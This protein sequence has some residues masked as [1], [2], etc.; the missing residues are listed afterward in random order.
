MSTQAFL[1]LPAKV[2]SVK[3]RKTNRALT[4]FHLIHSYEIVVTDD[5][6]NNQKVSIDGLRDNESCLNTFRGQRP[7]CVHG[8]MALPCILNKT[9][10]A[11]S[12]KQ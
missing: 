11:F 1:L 3:I 6:F 2:L 7:K 10:V 9:A 8:N 12:T 4:F 5:H